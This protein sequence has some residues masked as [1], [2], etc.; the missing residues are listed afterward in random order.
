MKTKNAP[1]TVTLTDIANAETA[2][3]RARV[4]MVIRSGV[5][6]GEARFRF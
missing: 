2:N 4:A 5:R 3:A 6:A 1:K